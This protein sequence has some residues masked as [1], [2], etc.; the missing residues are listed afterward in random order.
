MAT[1]TE[2]LNLINE[3]RMQYGLRHLDYQ[4][5][6]EYCTRR[7]H[8][9]RQLLNI[10]QR[11]NNNKKSYEPKELP[12]TFTDPRYLH[13]YIY[14]TE[15]A[16]AYAM[17]LKQESAN[18]LD[19][20]KRHHLIKRLRRAAQY[21]QQLC[22]ISEKQTVD[23]RTVLD[24]KAYAATMNGYYYFEKQE[25]QKALNQFVEA[26]TIYERFGN[27]SNAH[28]EALCYS[29]MDEIDP[30]IQF[31]AYKLQ[32]GVKNLKQNNQTA[33]GM[34]LLEAQLSKVCQ[35]QRK[36]KAQA[37]AHMTW[38]NEQFNIK[39]P[40]LADAIVKAQAT[41]S[42]S[43]Q[44]H[45]T[46]SVIEQFDQV[47]SDWADAEKRIKKLLKEDK[48]AISK[49]TSS[50]SAKATKELECTLTF[51]TYHFYSYSIQRNLALME[52]IKSS[53]G[54]IQNRIKL[55]DDSLKNV[56][57]IRELPFVKENHEFETELDILSNYYRAQR[58]ILV[59]LAYV[60][61]QKTPEATALYQRAQTYV[62]H[63]KLG[64]QQSHGFADD[65]VLKVS[66]EDIDQL[67]QTIR[68]GIWKACASWY[69]NNNENENSLDGDGDVDMDK[70]KNNSMEQVITKKMNQLQLNVSDEAALIK[71]LNVYPS[72]LTGNDPSKV[73][74]LIDFPPSFTPVSSKPFYFDLAANHI[75]YPTS[76]EERAKSDKP[77]GLWKYLGFSG[78]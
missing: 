56:D 1:T 63:T 72:T 25:W 36:E 43:L 54:K 62:L 34:D 18:S 21:S 15:R 40:Q 74:H 68:T 69:I 2:L 47:L 76:L 6:R 53:G 27:N 29:A 65:S 26:R 9:L 49:V 66:L 12:E 4:R 5:Y 50:K 11:A 45:H 46:K 70:K 42:S 73:P 78:N 48:E 30:N 28:Q 19:T 14:N 22:E 33:A 60:D 55:W 23:P 39:N 16:W 13:I 20:R 59:A 8:R 32:L 75:K 57:Y 3:S 61:M 38:R 52:E 10:T 77:S 7:I 37:L 44:D 41:T 51:V 58:C 67:E 24:T 17:E 35:E 71:R 64:L 31:C